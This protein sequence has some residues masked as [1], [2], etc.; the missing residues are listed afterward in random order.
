MY[1][2]NACGNVCDAEERCT[3]GAAPVK[4][5]RSTRVRRLAREAVLHIYVRYSFQATR[6][7]AVAKNIGVVEYGARHCVH[8]LVERE[9][10]PARVIT[11]RTDIRRCLGRAARYAIEVRHSS[12]I[13]GERNRICGMQRREF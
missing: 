4:H 13:L 11:R 5:E 12:L 6:R 8:W 7:K 2:S 1:I 3:P 9:S 10:P